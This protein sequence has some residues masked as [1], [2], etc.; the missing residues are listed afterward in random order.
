MDKKARGN[1]YAFAHYAEYEKK[2][3]LIAGKQARS[4]AIDYLNRLYSKKHPL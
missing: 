3:T 2:P 1:L 4:E